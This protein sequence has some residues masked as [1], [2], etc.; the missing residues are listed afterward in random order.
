MEEIQKLSDLVAS[1]LRN[2]NVQ[3]D[4]DDFNKTKDI[5]QEYQGKLIAISKL[6]PNIYSDIKKYFEAIDIRNAVKQTFDFINENLNNTDERFKKIIVKQG[7][8][9]GSAIDMIL[10]EYLSKNNKLGYKFIHGNDSCDTDCVCTENTFYNTE[11]KTTSDKIGNIS[12]SYTNS[13]IGKGKKYKYDIQ[14]FYIFITTE[15]SAENN[16]EINDIYIGKLCASDWSY[17]NSKGSNS[18]YL[19]KNV[20]DSHFI[21]L[22][23]LEM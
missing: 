3:Y 16:L 11:I 12:G 23:Y 13:G 5:I 1:N 18:V 8:V 21:N 7:K 4:N 20:R 22:K 19:T 17:S 14:H 2:N 9:V 15:K 6:D 10:P